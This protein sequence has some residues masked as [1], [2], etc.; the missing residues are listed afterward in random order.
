MQSPP[1]PARDLALIG[2]GNWGANLARCFDALGALRVIV[3]PAAATAAALRERFPSVALSTSMAAVLDDPAVRKLVIATP[4]ATHFELAQAA[5][6]A[7]KDVLVE[8]PMCLS[9]V[10]AELLVRLAQERGS[11]LMVGHL[12]QY[13]PCVQKLRELVASNAL[14]RILTISSNRL[15]LGRFRTDENALYSFAPHDVSLVL[16]LLDEQL[17][18]S[19]RCV[20]A[21]YLKPGVADSTLTVLQFASGA[22]A[23]LHVSWLNPFKEQ[24]LTVVGT[25]G[26]A[27]FDDTKPWTT[28]LLIARDYLRFDASRAPI[29]AANFEAVCVEEREPLALECRHFIDACNE[30]ARPRTDGREGLRVL[31]VLDMAQRSLDRDGERIVSPHEPGY[32]ADP[33]AII[34]EGASIGAG[35]KIWHFSHVMA[36]ARL[37]E[38]VSLGQNVFVAGGVTVGN[39]VKVQNNVSL[40]AGVELEADVFVGPSSVFTNVKNPRAEVD[41]RG[42]YAK[43]LVKQ[44]ASLGANCTVVCGVTLGRY[45]FIGAG[46]VVTHDVPDYALMLGNPARRV[47]WL[48][49]NGQRLVPDAEGRLICPETAERYHQVSSDKLVCLPLSEVP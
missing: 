43:T 46:A 26:M 49:R 29:A 32:F 45:C 33:S 7:G 39:D 5:L 21:S 23:Q 28:K 20:G 8:K 18:C 22:L 31:Q 48:S 37:G 19:V 34:D 2:A 16:S 38:R 25:G 11:T 35:S 27:V 41:R 47:G 1:P 3:E 9:G 10:E 17:P 14:G 42:S 40:Y 24:K 6:S 36:G 15:N 4:S 12:L 13:H 44:G 30:R